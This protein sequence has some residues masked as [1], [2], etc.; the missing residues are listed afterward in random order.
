MPGMNRDEAGRD[1]RRADLTVPSGD[2]TSLVANVAGAT[3]PGGG[4]RRSAAPVEGQ[5]RSFMRASGRMPPPPHAERALKVPQSSNRGKRLF[6]IVDQVFHVFDPNR[7]PYQSIRD[8]PLQAFLRRDRTVG[9]GGRVAG[10]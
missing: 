7:K 10:E 3:P 5:V 8:A 9:H 1:L 2:A 4:R 6:Q